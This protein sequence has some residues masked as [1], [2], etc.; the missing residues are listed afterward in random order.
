MQVVNTYHVGYP[1]L[2]R[3]GVGFLAVCVQCE[4]GLKV[5]SGIVALPHVLSDNY[6]DAREAAAQHV[7]QSGSPE[8]YERA[9]TFFPSLPRESYRA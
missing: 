1:D 9:I 8:R 5:Y 3:R 2:D 7:M 4:V 6:E